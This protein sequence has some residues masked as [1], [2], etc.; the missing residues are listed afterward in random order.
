MPVQHDLRRH[1]RLDCGSPSVKIMWCD[2]SGHDKFA[3][4]RALDVSETG[5]RLKVPEAIVVQSCVTIRSEN[6]KLHGQASVRYC[7]RLGTNYAVG[8]EFSRGVRWSPAAK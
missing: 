8:L 3:N 6:L 4:A 7:S 2:A 5:A 1:I